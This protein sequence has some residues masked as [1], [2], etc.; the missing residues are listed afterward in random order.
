MRNISVLDPDSD[1]N[2]V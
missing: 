2:P 1:T